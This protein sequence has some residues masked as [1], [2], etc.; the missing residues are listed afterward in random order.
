MVGVLEVETD[1]ARRGDALRE[2]GAVEPVAGLHVG[3][4]GQ[5][6]RAGDARHGREHL[7][8]RRLLAVLVPERIRHAAAGRGD[9]R[10]ARLLD[11]AR[12]AGVPGVGQ[13]QRV[14]GDMQRPQR[15]GAHSPGS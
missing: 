5:L 2:L 9:G 13:D 11:E 1:G 12:G 3:R 8:D 7:L 10:E 14:A 6:D 4:H 15:G